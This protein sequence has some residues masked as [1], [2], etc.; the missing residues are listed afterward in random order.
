MRNTLPA[1]RY[2]S[3][4]TASCFVRPRASSSS[5][6]ARLGS[7]GFGRTVSAR[8]S[9][10]S[11][12]RRASSGEAFGRASVAASITRAASGRKIAAPRISRSEKSL[13]IVRVFGG[14][15]SACCGRLPVR[16]APTAEA[17]YY[18]KVIIFGESSNFGKLNFLVE[19]LCKIVAS[20][21]ILVIFVA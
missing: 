14:Y 21:E 6:V 5:N 8:R 7:N 16:T 12:T 1:A 11:S 9:M 13:A 15:T 4:L 19:K 17:A 20:R 18:T 3:R 10:R 2:L